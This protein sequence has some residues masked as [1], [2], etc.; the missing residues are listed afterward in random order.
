VE[1]LEASADGLFPIIVALSQWGATLVAQAF[2]TGRLKV[3][4]EADATGRIG[5]TASAGNA[6][7]HLVVG[8]RQ[9]DDG[10]QRQTELGQKLIERLRLSP[11]PGVT[12]GHETARTLRTL[13]QLSD[14][15]IDFAIGDEQALLDEV[16]NSSSPL[17]ILRDGLA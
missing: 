4:I 2:P 1:F 16:R 6:S 15:G 17:R 7:D 14:E 11:R 9:V 3:D 12:I 5:A 13:E 8:N 10:I